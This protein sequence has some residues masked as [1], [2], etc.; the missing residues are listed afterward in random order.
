MNR[1]IWKS[2]I[3]RTHDDDDDKINVFS[4]GR[5]IYFFHEICGASASEFFKCMREIENEKSNKPIEIVINSEGGT[6][7][8][9]LAIYDKIRQCEYEVITKAY[10]YIASMAIIVFLAGDYRYASVNSSFMSHQGVAEE[11]GNPT[12]L[13][14]STR[15]NKR[16]ENI[17][18]SIIEEHTFQLERKIR[19]DY[20]LADYFFDVNK[21]FEEGYV[22]EIIHNKEIKKRRRKHLKKS[23]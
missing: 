10:G 11:Q 7:I 9:G 17:C 8:D 23:K 1:G 18:V 19:S 4:I 20:R 12:Q 14:V 5:T 21:A 2:N 13:E 22:H 16:L 6:V 3:K 15:E